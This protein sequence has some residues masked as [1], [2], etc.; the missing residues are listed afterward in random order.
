M[1]NSLLSAFLHAE[2]F[3]RHETTIAKQLH[4]NTAG[5]G[6]CNPA[7]RCVVQSQTKP[8]F[9]RELEG[10]DETVPDDVAVADDNRV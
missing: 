5:G 1:R 10:S 7:H 6:D 8:P 3:A 9:G 2:E 4:R